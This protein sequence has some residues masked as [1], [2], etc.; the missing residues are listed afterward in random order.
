MFFTRRASQSF[1]LT[2]VSCGRTINNQDGFRGVL[3]RDGR[4][5]HTEMGK[6]EKQKRGKLFCF[7]LELYV[8][9]LPPSGIEPIMHAELYAWEWWLAGQSVR[10]AFGYFNVRMESRWEPARSKPVGTSTPSHRIPSSHPRILM[11]ST[12]YVGLLHIIMVLLLA[13]YERVLSI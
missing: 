9:Y 13:I 7:S 8:S 11:T 6:C 5:D 12:C 3:G 10:L 1:L 4:E 2:I